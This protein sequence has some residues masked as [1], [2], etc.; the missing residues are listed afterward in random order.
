MGT[1]IARM[2]LML[3]IAAVHQRPVV[4]VVMFYSSSCVH[5]QSVI[6]ETL[7]PLR[8]RFGVGLEL[9]YVDVSGGSG[10]E[11]FKAAGET[12]EIPPELQGRVPTAIVGS[13]ALVGSDQIAHNLGALI[14]RG[15]D[16]GGTPL[17]DIPGMVQYYARIR[18]LKAQQQTN[19]S[20]ATGAPLLHRVP[21]ADRFQQDLAANVFAI[22]VLALQVITL[23][24]LGLAGA[25]AITGGRIPTWLAYARNR[26]LIIVGL[27]AS[28]ASLSLLLGTKP[29]VSAA[30]LALVVNACLWAALW[31]IYRQKRGGMLSVVFLAAAGLLVAVYLSYVEVGQHS[32]SCGAFGQCNTVQSSRYARLAGIP[33]GVLGPGGYSLIL[34][35]A[36]VTRFEHPIAHRALLALTVFGVAFSAYLTFLEPFVIGA[37]CVWCITSALIMV[38]L[39]W[40]VFPA[41]L[42]PQPNTVHAD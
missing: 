22:G 34:V 13:T 9:V 4:Y 14:Q 5:C 35:A 2:L 37:T 8:D 20:H 28:V 10:A 17:P 3:G 1:L 6:T 31:T 25:A 40:L 19:P 36:L 11:L 33:V 41:A 42:A 24:M 18:D 29:S 23:A 26:A 12:L 21:W 30:G 7:P 39:L 27:A 38:L 15:L 32:A 16:E